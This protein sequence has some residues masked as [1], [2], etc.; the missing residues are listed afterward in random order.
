MK[1]Y[2]V[3]EKTLATGQK[4]SI[5]NDVYIKESWH[6]RAFGKEDGKPPAGQDG[7]KT[8]FNSY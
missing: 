8:Q 4:P 6:V 7:A 2:Y 3:K 5:G 1:G